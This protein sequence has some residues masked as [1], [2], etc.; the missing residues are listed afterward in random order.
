MEKRLFG[1]NL[2][3]GG[4]ILGFG[5]VTDKIINIEEGFFWS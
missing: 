2:G 1:E 5:L 3:D 4:K